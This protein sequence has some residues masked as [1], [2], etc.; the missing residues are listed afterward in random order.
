MVHGKK[1]RVEAGQTAKMPGYIAWLYVYGLASQLC[2]DEK[3]F[4]RWNEEGFRQTYYD[5]VVV[6]ADAAFQAV[7]P[8]AEPEVRTFEEVKPAPGTGMSYEPKAKR[9]RPASV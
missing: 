6:G 9:G 4:A 7:T 8:E 1:Y 3:Q 2:Q 5:Q